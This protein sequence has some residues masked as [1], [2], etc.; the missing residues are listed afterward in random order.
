[1][2]LL[3]DVTQINV[4]KKKKAKLSDGGGEGKAREGE[5]SQE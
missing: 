3:T 2:I 1:M 5:A 4:I